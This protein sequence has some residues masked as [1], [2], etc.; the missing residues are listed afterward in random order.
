MKLTFK[1]LQQDNFQVEV[2][3]TAKVIEVK[4]AI[5]AAKGK[6]L[7]DASTIEELKISEKDF[8]VVMVSKPKPVAAPAPV[9]APAPVT[10][11]VPVTPT[12]P[13][14]P[15]ATPASAVPPADSVDTPVNPETLT[16]TTALATGAVYENAVSNLMEMGFPRDQVTHAMR[17][18]FN[19]P[20]RAAEYLMTGI[21]DSV[22]REFASTAPVLSDTTT[23]PSSTAA[24][25]TPAAPAATQHIN[26]FEAAAAQAAQSRSGAAASHAPGAGDASTLS[27]LRNSPQ[28]QQLRQ[29]VHSQP[30]LLQPLL[31]QIGQTNPELL[32]LIS[33]N[34]GQFLQMLNEGSEEG[35]NIASAEGADDTA[36]MGQQITVT[37]EENE[38]ILRLAA[39]GFDRGLA[40]EAYFACDKNEELAANYLFDM[41]Q[42]DDWQ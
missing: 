20:D 26:L 14:A 32:Q 21:P 31:Q 17:T 29:L 27:F 12:V 39:L 34:Q 42:G 9:V 22:A 35:G 8:I 36:A 25:A 18:A 28:F 3:Q 5:L 10:P 15:T 2:E 23:T 30:Q 33:Q 24:P 4:E 38:A 1:T 19:N 13:V 37:T 41:G 7:N 11:A 16:T 40:L 6:I